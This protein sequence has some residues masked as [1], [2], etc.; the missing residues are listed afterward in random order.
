[1][2]HHYVS[3]QAFFCLFLLFS[4]VCYYYF[5]N[6]PL[7]QSDT[8]KNNLCFC[9]ERTGWCPPVSWSCFV[10]EIWT[11]EYTPAR[12]STPPWVPSARRA[13]SKSPCFQVRHTGRG[14]H[15]A[16]EDQIPS[17][18]T[19]IGYRRVYTIWR[20]ICGHL[21]PV[22]HFISQVIALIFMSAFSGTFMEGLWKLVAVIQKID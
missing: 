10:W 14:H 13:P 7:C 19:E 17:F 18:Y 3:C 5:T 15:R 11:A 2:H 4:L 8:L 16:A 21:M 12:L 22:F 6:Q 9:R 1:M 20:N